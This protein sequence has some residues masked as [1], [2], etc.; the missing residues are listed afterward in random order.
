MPFL[1]DDLVATYGLLPSNHE[2]QFLPDG[3]AGTEKTIAIMQKLVSDGKRD[4]QVRELVGKIINGE[5]EGIPGCKSKDYACYAKSIYL[6]C[7]DKIKYV[8][9]PHI[10]EYVE[11]PKRILQTKVADCDSIC[12]LMGSMFE[13][14]G[15]EAQFVTIKAD[16]SRRDEFSHVYMRVKV[17]RVGWIVADAT[18][19]TKWF[20][21]EPPGAWEK[22]FWPGSTDELEYPMDKQPSV[23]V[24]ASSQLAGRGFSMY[25]FAG[26]GATSTMTMDELNKAYG[27]VEWDFR[28]GI[29][30]MPVVATSQFAGDYNSILNS[31]KAF[32]QKYLVRIVPNAPAPAGAAT[33]LDKIA[34]ALTAFKRKVQA[35]TGQPTREAPPPPP[36]LVA[37]STPAVG[38]VAPQT[39][40]APESFLA[41]YKWYLVAGAG[42]AAMAIW[43]KSRGKRAVSA[44]PRRGRGR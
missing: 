26:L 13:N 42:V 32:A 38:P 4:I 3:L 12:V 18:M 20:G 44:N 29:A 14:A 27:L 25:G 17:P 1:A 2:R 37:P 41:K 9:D 19:P 16:P 43:W 5:I 33:D 15:L 28:T 31:L 39:Q 6:Y 23:P 11:V 30:T 40:A 24:S 22:R 7:R 36:A 10:V 8:Y 35:G 34:T 21:W